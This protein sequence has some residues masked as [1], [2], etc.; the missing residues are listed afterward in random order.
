M[1][2][3][4]ANELDDKNVND[5]QLNSRAHCELYKSAMDRIGHKMIL[6]DHGPTM[7]GPLDEASFVYFTVKEKALSR[8]SLES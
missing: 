5:S 6:V 7:I 8:N 1:I 4:I 3:T 2:V